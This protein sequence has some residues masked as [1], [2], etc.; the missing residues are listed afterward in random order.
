MGSQCQMGLKG[1]GTSTI[2]LHTRIAYIMGVLQGWYSVLQGKHIIFNSYCNYDKQLICLFFKQILTHLLE[3]RPQFCM[4]LDFKWP[5]V[6][7]ILFVAPLILIKPL[8]DL[9]KT[10]KVNNDMISA[11]PNTY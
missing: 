4:Q 9:Q 7:K 6:K 3:R 8:Q 5:E 2:H 1:P 10:Y 11:I